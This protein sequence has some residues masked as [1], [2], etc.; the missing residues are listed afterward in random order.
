[1]YDVSFFETNTKYTK[2]KYLLD[3]FLIGNTIKTVTTYPRQNL[4]TRIINKIDVSRKVRYVPV[5]LS[6]DSYLADGY[7]VSPKYFSNIRDILL[8]EIVLKEKSEKFIEW[9]G[10]IKNAKKPL[11]LHARRTD[12]TA[13]TL[14]TC[15]D[16]SYFIRAL[17]NFDDDCEL[18]CFT[19]NIPWLQEALGDRKYT[20]VS[21]EGCTDYEELI[22]MSLCDNFVI[23]NS[24]YSWWGSWLSQNPN[25]KIISPKRWYIPAAWKQADEDVAGD[26][27]VRID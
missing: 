23:P 2:R 9:E 13:G 14:F 5:D 20:M 3:V 18:F 8:S 11:M 26:G 16:E 6:R 12:M 27:W 22:L 25:K 1:V 24:T 10:R 4:F 15:L 7:Y 21:G 19:D 17:G